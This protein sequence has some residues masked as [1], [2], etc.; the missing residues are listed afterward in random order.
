MNL[1]GRLKTRVYLQES[2]LTPNVVLFFL[3]SVRKKEH[4]QG[5]VGVGVGVAGRWEEG[6]ERNGNLLGAKH[7]APIRPTV[8]AI[9]MG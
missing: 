9:Q 2:F 5:D 6:S 3:A 8:S 4:R 7:Q 1:K